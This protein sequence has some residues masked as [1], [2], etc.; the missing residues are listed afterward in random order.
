MQEVA[1]VVRGPSPVEQC[2]GKLVFLL[3]HNV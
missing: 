1:R 2:V 3:S